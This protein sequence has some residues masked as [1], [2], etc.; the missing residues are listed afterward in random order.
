M[1]VNVKRTTDLSKLKTEIVLG[2]KYSV[3][4]DVFTL[5]EIKKIANEYP[6]GVYLNFDKIIHEFELDEL[7]E[8]LKEVPT[9]V[10]GYYFSDFG[11]FEL[12][13]ELGLKDKLIYNAPTLVANYMDAKVILDKGIKRVVISKEITLEEVKKIIEFNKNVE[14]LIHGKINMFYSKRKLL[15]LFYEYSKLDKEYDKMSLVEQTRNDKLSILEDQ[16][17]THIFSNGILDSYD[18]VKELDCALRIDG[19]YLEDDELLKE[20]DT[21]NK[22]LEDKDVD[23]DLEGKNSG[24]YYK[25]TVYQKQK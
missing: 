7:R 25:E 11:M 12:F 5:E 21:Y 3:R 13:D 24:F 16:N 14:V 19:F 8:Y 18:E 23:L 9:N 17:G 6:Y 2:T 15:S 20:I 22:I 1:I 10:S 4:N